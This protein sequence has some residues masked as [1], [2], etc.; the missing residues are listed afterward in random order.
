MLPTFPSRYWSTI[1]LPVIFSLAAWSPQIQTGFHVSR[2]TQVPIL[3]ASRYLYGPF[4]LCGPTFQTVPVPDA[5]F[6][7]GPTTPA[8]PQRDRFRLFPFRSPLLWES[9]FLSFP[10]GTKMFQFPA[11]APTISRRR[12]FNPPGFP[13]RT[14]PDQFLFA[15]PRSFSQLTTSFIASGSQGILRSL[16]FSFSYFSS[17]YIATF[18]SQF[19]LV[20][21]MKLQSHIRNSKKLEFLIIQ[22][23]ISF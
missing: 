19:L 22:T 5:V 20:C 4:T 1:G 9:I 10:A 18:T 16:L 8:A 13:I 2:P 23:I 7:T 6:M 15:D 14:S 3:T 21:L 12:V 17:E 11:S